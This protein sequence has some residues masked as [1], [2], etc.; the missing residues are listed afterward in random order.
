LKKKGV[1]KNMK[2]MKTGIVLLALLLAGMAMV[3]MVSAEVSDQARVDDEA[4]IRELFN[5]IDENI[6]LIVTE[7]Y[8]ESDQADTEKFS[9]SVSEILTKYDENLDNIILLLDKITNVHLDKANRTLLKEVIV[10]ERFKRVSDEILMEKRGLKEED[11]IIIQPKILGIVDNNSE[12]NRIQMEAAT[13]E[14]LILAQ[15]SPDIYGGF[16]FDNALNWYTVFGGNNLY[17]VMVWPGSPT[18]YRLCYYD[19]DYPDLELDI[20]YDAL[21]IIQTGSLLDY[22]QF[23]V[24][25]SNIHYSLSY[26]YGGTYGLPFGIHGSPT[27][28]KS[29]IIYVANIWNHDIGTTNNNPDMGQFVMTVPYIQQ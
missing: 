19:E 27:L 23:E 6:R 11:A 28:P 4:K 9:V 12:I 25:D 3:P 18:T 5:P 2:T 29:S 17:Q 8:L 26:S 16:G 15:S 10:S 24:S 20:E 7:N 1:D 21:R 14:T 13:T 22:A